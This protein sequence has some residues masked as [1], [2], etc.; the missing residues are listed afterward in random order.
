LGTPLDRHLRRANLPVLAMD[1]PDSFIPSLSYWSFVANVSDREAIE[2]L[3]FLVGQQSGA[4][5]ANPGL[6]AQV[7]RS[8]N[9]RDALDHLCHLVSTEVSRVAL[10]LAPA[11]NNTHRVYYRPSFG[12]EHPGYVHFQWYGLMVVIEVIRLFTHSGWQ[13]DHVGLGTLEVPSKAVRTCFPDTRFDT[14]QPQCFVALDT[15]ILAR[16]PRSKQSPAALSTDYG[17]IEPAADFPG[18][19]GQMLRS[20]LMDGET[21]IHIAAGVAGLSV[22]T[23]QRRLAKEKLTYATLRSRVQLE[24]ATQLLRTTDNNVTEIAHRLGYSDSS[25]FSRAFRRMAGV[26]PRE[27]RK[28]SR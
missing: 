1:D 13:P 18:A 23:L 16:R 17:D 24:T 10:W 12:C 9:L 28:T 27:Y 20:Y 7:C 25:H 6:T 2:D 22:R 19:L 8:P 3:G 4:D 15:E 26:S 11:E 14:G 5:A 21:T